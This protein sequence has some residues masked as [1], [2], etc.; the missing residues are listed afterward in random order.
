M[1]LITEYSSEGWPLAI[2]CLAHLPLVKQQV[3]PDRHRTQLE[4]N[5]LRESMLK[6]EQSPKPI[7]HNHVEALLSS[8]PGLQRGGAC[9]P[10]HTMPPDS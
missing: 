10:P 4:I 7:H 5:I 6:G 3:I 2:S 8:Q 9:K 1:T